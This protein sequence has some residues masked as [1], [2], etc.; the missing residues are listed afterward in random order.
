VGTI[1]CTDV[2]PHYY[3]FMMSPKILETNWHADE[4]LIITQISGDVDQSDIERW[5][6]SL[7]NTLDKLLDLVNSKF[8]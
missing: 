2:L 1:N 5:A 7:I 8:L 6:H 3:F 4:G